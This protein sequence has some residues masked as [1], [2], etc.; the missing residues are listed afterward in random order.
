MAVTHTRRP[1]RAATVALAAVVWAAG[2]VAAPLVA[3]GGAAGPSAWAAA[4][5][6]RA[7]AVICHQQD[8]RSMHPGGLRM[9][10]CARCAG[11]YAGGALGAIAAAAWVA[12]AAGPRRLPLGRARAAAIACGLPT[13]AAWAG[14]H[15]GGLPVTALARAAL[16][17]PLGAAVAAIVALWAGGASFDDNAGGSALH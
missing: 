13:L 5:A 8:A 2:L 11:L 17:I 15:L 4:V 10:V 6:Y 1:A 14:E 7:G 9:P 16:A 12:A 3:A